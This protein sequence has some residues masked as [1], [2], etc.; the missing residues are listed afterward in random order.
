MTPGTLLEHEVYAL[1]QGAGF[2]S[3]GISSGKERPGRPR[4]RLK[5]S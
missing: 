4:R 2:E 1:L 3:R 5:I